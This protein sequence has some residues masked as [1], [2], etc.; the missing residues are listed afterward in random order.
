MIQWNRLID[1]EVDTLVRNRKTVRSP[2]TDGEALSLYLE[3]D[4]MRFAKGESKHLE[5]LK[6]ELNTGTYKSRPVFEKLI[7]KKSNDVRKVYTLT[8]R[9]Y[10]VSR[11]VSTALS[12]EEP[13]SRPMSPREP[14]LELVSYL[15]PRESQPPKIG[16]I[17]RLDV[18]SYFDSI[19]ERKV[20]KLLDR[21]N[22]GEEYRAEVGE[23]LSKE[24]VLRRLSTAAV[25][26]E[27][28]KVKERTSTFTPQGF[29]HS[30][31]IAQ[32]YIASFL[33]DC[34]EKKGK[35]LGYGVCAF[36]YV[37]DIL[38]LF[39]NKISRWKLE[40]YY[41]KLVICFKS[42]GLSLHSRDSSGK[43]L[44]QILDSN[45]RTA[46]RFLGLGLSSTSQRHLRVSLPQSVLKSRKT[47]IWR[48]FN[49][50]FGSNLHPRIEKFN[51]D[52]R[53][54]LLKYR[55]L[56]DSAGCRYKGKGHGFVNYWAI[57]ND[58]SSFVLLDNFVNKCC[59]S[60]KVMDKGQPLV[61]SMYY[62]S[63]KKVK[64]KG[65]RESVMFNYDTM[66]HSKR[67]AILSEQF[68]FFPNYLQSMT[69]DQLNK[70]WHSTLRADLTDIPVGGFQYD[71]WR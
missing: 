10:L 30:A 32:W 40:F 12:E 56:R 60:F 2:G 36:R 70:T 16:A 9:D 6:R 54:K 19:P 58:A 61:E 53:V 59:R 4:G 49:R 18:K 26:Q 20:S 1:H 63:F 43:T 5:R 46:F 67:A 47:F 15:E 11:A 33:N 28:A 23:S 42:H 29:P 52:E 50:Y 41:W 69:E 66:D 45:H 35:R 48:Q 8:S 51:F 17:M 68:G 25:W 37:D 3:G 57:S 65:F 39:P 21:L 34:V 64:T 71:N 62:L 7:P 13:L 55:I 24:E 14:L 44:V 31:A 27:N 22:S 38:I